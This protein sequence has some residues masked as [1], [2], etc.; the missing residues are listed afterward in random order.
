VS[1]ISAHAC[2]FSSSPFC[3]AVISIHLHI[4]TH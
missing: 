3:C 1:K 2:F 4:Q